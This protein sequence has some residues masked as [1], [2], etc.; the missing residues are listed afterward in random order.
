MKN[1]TISKII[2]NKEILY[3]T[4]YD[5]IFE[6]GENI[7][8]HDRTNVSTA[9]DLCVE[10]TNKCNLKCQNCFCHSGN[11]YISL[12][13]FKN[14]LSEY[15]DRIIRICLSGGEPLLNKNILPILD[16]LNTIP[17]L[18]KVLSTNGLFLNQEILS[19][20]KQPFWTVAVSLHGTRETHNTYVGK[21]VYDA[22]IHSINELSEEHI[23]T[24]IY[25]VLHNKIDNDDILSLK[26]IKKN[27]NISVLRL[28]KIRKYGR[29][30]ES[31]SPIIK[32]INEYIEKGIFYKNQKSKTFFVSARKE[33]RN[34][35]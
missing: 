35:N 9:K 8:L 7:N 26:D 27:Y 21:N 24:H 29:Y 12:N 23:N 31:E 6:K 13:S 18:G 3:D 30:Q 1:T 14:I 28:I 16:Y 19:R 32:N 2:D 10:L 17:N 34:T 22:V 20:L 25:T 15:N 11:D 4:I 5:D 33:K